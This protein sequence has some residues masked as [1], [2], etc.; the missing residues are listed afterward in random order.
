MEPQRLFSSL[1]RQYI[2]VSIFRACAE[3][4]ASEYASRLA[5]MQAAEKNLE[6][7]LD[8]VTGR[9]R[10]LR[11]NVITSELLDVVAGFEALTGSTE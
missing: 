10:W 6:E 7:R 11:Q 4:L 9:Y 3:S 5:A 2:F 8:E 1:L